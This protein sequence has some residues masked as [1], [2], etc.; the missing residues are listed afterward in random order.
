MVGRKDLFS[1]RMLNSYSSFRLSYLHLYIACL[2]QSLRWY[3]LLDIL[4]SLHNI[5][6]ILVSQYLISFISISRPVFFNS[7]QSLAGILCYVM[8]CLTHSYY[9]RKIKKNPYLI[10]IIV[11]MILQH[12]FIT[13]LP[14]E[15]F[16]CRKL[17]MTIESV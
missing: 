8:F 12:C 16:I 3:S 15:H 7:Q 1:S 17:L 5:L 13:I 4:I 9:Q 14:P 6:M 11:T 10:W 2:C